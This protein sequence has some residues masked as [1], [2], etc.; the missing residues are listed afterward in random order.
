MKQMNFTGRFSNHAY[1]ANAEA[2]S[3][4][5]SSRYGKSRRAK[6]LLL[7]AEIE[8]IVKAHKKAIRMAGK[9]EEVEGDDTLLVVDAN[10]YKTYWHYVKEQVSKR[11]SER[12]LFREALRESIVDAIYR[13]NKDLSAKVADALWASIQSSMK[14]SSYDDNWNFGQLKHAFASLIEDLSSAAETESNPI[15]RHSYYGVLK[16]VKGASWTNGH[17]RRWMKELNYSE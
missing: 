2:L 5:A 16:K 1:E 4:G 15:I 11:N 8:P 3:K 12:E 9:P 14:S 13:R 7:E 6:S 17:I 10:V